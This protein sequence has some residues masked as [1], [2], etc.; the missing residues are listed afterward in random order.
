MADRPDAN[1]DSPHPAP[2]RAGVPVNDAVAARGGFFLEPAVRRVIAQVYACTDF[3]LP[4]QLEGEAVHGYRIDR[5][6]KRQVTLAPYNFQPVLRD[7]AEDVARA[8]VAAARDAGPRCTAQ[9]RLHHE[10]NGTLVEALRLSMSASSVESLV[11]LSGGFDAVM[12]AM[13][14]RH[15][16]KLRKVQ[17][18]I[19]R[20]EL[21]VREFRDRETLSDFYQLLVRVY[22]DKHRMLAQP[23]I[24]FEKLLA[25]PPG[26][27]TVRAYGVSRADTGALL[28]GV[29]VLADEAQ[30]CYAWGATD[31]AAGFSNLSILLIA[32][33]MRDA[34][35]AG[36]AVFS[37]GATP[38]SHDAL[39][40]FKRNW[41]A[42]EHLLRTYHWREQ[43]A[44]GDLHAGYPVL[45]SIVAHAPT[46]LL[47]GVSAPVVRLLA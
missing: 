25:L 17:A 11:P 15:R 24:L 30:W 43:P 40:Q 19:E 22:R 9:I 23:E 5:P 31:D 14:A 39:R 16:T 37:L 42:Q 34:A 41:G 2:L 6:W 3:A 28:G 38:L 27:R 21:I 29:F 13:Q 44:E 46:W 47:R 36:A 18:S 35:A 4:V 32:A 20:G 10:L 1:H 33:A 26:R 7:R 8:L 12:A 45:K